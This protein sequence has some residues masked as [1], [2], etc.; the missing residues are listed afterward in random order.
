MKRK[1][2]K[3]KKMMYFRIEQEDD[4]LSENFNDN[5]FKMPLSLK[6]SVDAFNDIQENGLCSAENCEIFRDYCKEYL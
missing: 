2:R 5:T 3:E 6:Y 1:R 4:E